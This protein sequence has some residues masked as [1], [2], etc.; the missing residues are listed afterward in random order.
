MVPLE[1]KGKAGWLAMGIG[2]PQIHPQFNHN[3]T[4]AH[5]SKIAII[6]RL[7]QLHSIEPTTYIQ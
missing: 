1:R 4:T 2:W 5:T 6:T 3:S 7:G